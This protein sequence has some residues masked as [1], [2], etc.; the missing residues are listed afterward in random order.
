MVGG[1]GQQGA[2]VDFHGPAAGWGHLAAFVVDEGARHFVLL[3]VVVE[4]KLFALVCRGWC[5][6]SLSSW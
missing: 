2:A 3:F 5:F 6:C 1:G 4:N